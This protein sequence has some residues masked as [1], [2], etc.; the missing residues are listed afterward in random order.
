[1][2]WRRHGDRGA[3]GDPDLRARLNDAIKALRA[4]G[5]Y[6]EINRKYFKYDIY[7]G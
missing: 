2:V 1:M 3:Q 7:G 4:N 6:Q 5:K